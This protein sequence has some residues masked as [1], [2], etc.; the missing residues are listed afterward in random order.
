MD[1]SLREAYD[2]RRDFRKKAFR[3]GCYAPFVSLYFNTFGDVLACC[4]N[5]TY[6]LGNVAQQRLGDIWRGRKINSLRKA[7]VNYTFGAGCEFCE[8][9]IAGGNYEGAFTSIYEEYPVQ[10][11][12]PEWPTVIEFAGSNTCNFECI[13]C[14]GEFSSLIRTHREG[15]PPLPKV[16]SDQFFDDLREFLPH[17]QMIKFLGGEPFLAQECFRIWEMIMA[18]GLTI[19]CHVTTNAS[20]YNSK[21]ESILEALPVSLSVSVDGA[22]KETVEKIRVNSN[23]EEFIENLRRFRK[24]TKR[25]GTFM[26]F[27]HCLMIQNWHEF[28][29]VLQLAES[30][31]CQVFVNTVISPTKNSLYAL[32]PEELARIVGEMEKQEGPLKRKLKR[33]WPVWE[34]QISN[35]KKNAHERMGERLTK[36]QDAVLESWHE[37]R[38][39]MWQHITA[40]WALV[41][42]GLFSEALEEARKTP[43]TS[44]CYYYALAVC[45]HCRR[46]MGDLEGAEED[47]ARAM[48]L[49]RRRPEAFIYRAWIRFDQGRL[50]EGV[51]DALYAR[52]L[53]IADNDLEAEVC[54]ILGFI[55]SRQGKTDE[56]TGALD[57]LMELKPADPGIRVTRGEAFYLAGLREQALNEADAALALD[58]NHADA[59]RLKSDLSQEVFTL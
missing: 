52:D 26:G 8:W 46:L 2:T 9:Q 17:L 59:I 40:S 56:A 31:D 33:N 23:Y 1:Q 49:S 27:A 34:S 5:V 45:G 30:L 37:G 29:D 53:I 19:P 39:A 57:R 58:S 38:E 4:K 47:L 55:Y 3:S 22:T 16:Y 43:E 6:V 32:P 12:E 41:K 11:M 14:S 35:L 54:E 10:S 7:L 44:A 20:Q 36:Y 42:K 51:K 48:K 28:G 21:V 24:Y 13:M 50:D 25:R 18:D 15:L